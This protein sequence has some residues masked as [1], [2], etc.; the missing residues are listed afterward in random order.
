MSASSIQCALR[1]LVAA[2][3]GFVTLALA[4]EPALCIVV[5]SSAGG[6]ADLLAR[7]FRESVV[8]NSGLSASVE[9]RPGASGTI[10]AQAVA[11][12]STNATT[13]LV[14]GIGPT[15]AAPYL[16]PSL[17]YRPAEDLRPVTLLATSSMA[18][19]VSAAGNLRSVADLVAHA[20]KRVEVPVLY[21]ASGPGTANQLC[22]QELARGAM[23]QA[24][25]VP[26]QGDVQ[27]Q[28]SV[29]SGDVTF[30]FMAPS[31]AI[32]LERAG[33]VRILATSGRTRAPRLHQVPTLKESGLP[34][35]ECLA[36]TMVFA[37]SGTRDETV[38][39][40]ARAW[41]SSLADPRMRAAIQAA[42]FEVPASAST[43][44]T[45]RLLAAERVRLER[46][47]SEQPP[48][49]GSR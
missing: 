44:E 8:T 1:A 11:S 34:G 7:L 35:V 26:F 49:Q 31:V 29:A 17:R 20:K 45:E 41:Q 32:P 9:N 36:W 21:A 25:S 19:V 16:L 15:V 28:V 23:F 47:L 39:D 43:S 40:L 3:A 46:V 2:L 12:G 27:A 4:A 6:P 10:A 5:A 30:M 18:L 38:A 42:G 24:Q 22:A 14:A 48:G 33:R 13:V 37:P